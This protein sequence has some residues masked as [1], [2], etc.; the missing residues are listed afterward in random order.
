MK[1]KYEHTPE[2]GVYGDCWRT[3]VAYIL[4]LPRDEVPHYPEHGVDPYDTDAAIDFMVDWL[5]SYNYGYFSFP[6]K[7]D[8]DVRELFDS[9]RLF[10][11]AIIVVGISTILC[12]HCVVITPGGEMIDPS[13]N[14]IIGPCA[15]GHYWIEVITPYFVPP[16]SE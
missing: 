1:Q 3:C 16:P 4:G 8:G 15:D 10:N 7:W 11:T 5:R 9:R 6:F 14:G 13:G 12:D 2:N